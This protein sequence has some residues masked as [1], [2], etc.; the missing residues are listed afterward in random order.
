MPKVFGQYKFMVI[1]SIVFIFDTKDHTG[2][3]KVIKCKVS[4]YV[5]G[6]GK[7]LGTLPLLITYKFYV[8]YAVK[9]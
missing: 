5:S 7:G 6:S 3:L 9:L 8:D 2:S 1:H 4:E